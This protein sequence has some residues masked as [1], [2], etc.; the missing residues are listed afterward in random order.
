[1]KCTD[2]HSKAPSR[3]HHLV[4]VGLQQEDRDHPDAIEHEEGENHL[5]TELLQPIADLLEERSQQSNR[6][7]A[8]L[9]LWSASWSANLLLLL[10]IFVQWFEIF[11]YELDP[12]LDLLAGEVLLGP[13]AEGVVLDPARILQVVSHHNLF[14]RLLDSHSWDAAYWNYFFTRST[15][16]NI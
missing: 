1:M 8:D 16:R 10:R 12:E 4:L 13:V 3:T 7:S 14:L 2:A 9:H 11:L 5:I 15:F 6:G